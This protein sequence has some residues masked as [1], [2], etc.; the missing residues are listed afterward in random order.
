[1]KERIEEVRDESGIGVGEGSMRRGN[2]QEKRGKEE[3]R[4][5]K[6]KESLE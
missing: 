5:K 4:E 3:R 2:P 6:S 1:M